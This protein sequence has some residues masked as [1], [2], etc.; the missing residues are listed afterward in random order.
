MW[1]T[2]LIIMIVITGLFLFTVTVTFTD[3]LE[4]VG[5]KL[6]E[7]RT[8]WLVFSILLFI[9]FAIQRQLIIWELQW[10]LDEKRDLQQRID[11]IAEFRSEAINNY[12][13]KTPGRE[14]FPDWKESY[15]SWQERVENYLKEH[16]PYAV[17]E[18][19]TDLGTVPTGNFVHVSKDPEIAGQHLHILQMLVKQMSIFEAIIEKH[20]TVTF[21]REPTLIEVIKHVRKGSNT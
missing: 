5:L 3:V 17:V 18:M 10:R 13:A 15:F 8:L 14:E 11:R 2:K 19:F 16:F 12:Y 1:I 20:S 7:N 6:E 4:L 9:L 21:Q